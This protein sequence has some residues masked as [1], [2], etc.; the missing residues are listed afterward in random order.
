MLQDAR[1]KLDAQNT[2]DGGKLALPQ[3][4]QFLLGVA[5]EHFQA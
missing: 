3:V 4:F 5:D 2:V 1:K